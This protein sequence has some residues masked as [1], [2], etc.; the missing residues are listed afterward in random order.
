MKG[1]A[2]LFVDSADVM[3]TLRK[4]CG[5][6]EYT[7]LKSLIA[8]TNC[9]GIFWE[10]SV[11]INIRSW[12]YVWGCCG[13]RWG[14]WF[15]VRDYFLR[16]WW[17][18]SKIKS[19]FWWSTA[20]LKVSIHF[21]RSRRGFLTFV[22]NSLKIEFLKIKIVI[23]PSKNKEKIK[24]KL[25]TITT[26]FYFFRDKPQDQGDFFIFTRLLKTFDNPF[27]FSATLFIGQEKD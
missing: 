20:L 9:G 13:E 16:Y 25:F 17:P 1:G 19:D 23:T 4:G 14:F 21:L 12:V 2:P 8:K 11:S 18:F 27:Y 5:W 24:T 6:L 10:V 26:T 3:V 15:L 7:K 22:T